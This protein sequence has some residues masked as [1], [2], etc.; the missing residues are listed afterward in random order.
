MQGRRNE[1]IPF[2]KL[3]EV[4]EG[5]P[6]PEEKCLDCRGHGVIVVYSQSSGKP[7]SQAMCPTCGGRC[8]AP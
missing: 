8:Y 7:L 5:T 4:Q 2:A 6:R 3:S 1:I